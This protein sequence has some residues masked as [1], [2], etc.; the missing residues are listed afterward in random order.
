LMA[1]VAHATGTPSGTTISNTATM[2][3][4]VGGVAQAAIG[5]SPTGNTSGAGTAT[6]FVVDKKINLTV[7]AN[8]AT[9][10]SVSPGA[11]AAVSTFTVTNT[12]NDPQDFSLASIQ[13]ASGVTLFSGTDNF[14]AGSC[15]QF[16]E[17]GATAGY[18]AAQDTAIV[19]ASLAS[20]SS[21]T[22]YVVC[23]I[24]S[25][26]VNG[27]VAVIGL[28]ATAKVA[29]SAGA[30]ALTQTSGANTAGVDTVFADDAGSG[31]A[32]RDAAFSAR[33]AYKVT[34]STLTVTK[35]TAP[36]C[37]PYNAGT[38]P[39][40]I[41][42]SIVRYTIT[43]SN[44]AGAGASAILTTMTDTPSTN[45]TFDPNLVTGAGGTTGCS[46]GTG[47]PSKAT[48]AGFQVQSSAAGRALGGTGA[49]GYFT[50]ANDGDGADLNA[51]TITINFALAL[52]A[53]GSYT[54]GELKAGETAT[55]LY[56]ITVN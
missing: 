12:G 35:T 43:V 32:I 17:S 49:T 2:N 9:F 38:N 15:S 26:Q 41:P 46:S 16:I 53:G 34:A 55:V 19:I 28:L 54:A 4:S 33:D 20:G 51:G 3:Y 50:T 7:T 27:D 56:N 13:E 22:V 48:G 11:T 36:L 47:T 25:A 24:P 31:D 6:T 23:S 39:K 37:D 14:N 44:A 8:D 40:E 29:G 45:V 18:Q 10:V 52:P 30:T 5:S 21:A 42:G 1:G